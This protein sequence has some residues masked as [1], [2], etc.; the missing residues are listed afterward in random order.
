MKKKNSDYFYISYLMSE[1]VFN[2]K[3]AE[4]ILELIDRKIFQPVM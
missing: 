3:R 4:K 1:G 2:P